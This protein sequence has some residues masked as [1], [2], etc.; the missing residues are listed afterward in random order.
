MAYPN[1]LKISIKCYDGK[2]CF[3]WKDKVLIALKTNK[4]DD[5]IEEKFTIEDEDK[6]KVDKTEKDNRA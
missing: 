3:W 2:D 1:L 5:A 6:V 4:C